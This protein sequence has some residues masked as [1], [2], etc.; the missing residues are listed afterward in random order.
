MLLEAF[1]AEQFRADRLFGGGGKGSGRSPQSAKK[2]KI[3]TC[4]SVP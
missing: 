2:Q 4:L 3:H 1:D